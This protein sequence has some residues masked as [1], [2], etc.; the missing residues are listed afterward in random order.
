MLGLGT[1]P[2][3]QPI[4]P[5]VQR[6]R[7]A[8]R[9]FVLG[10]YASAVH[11][12]WSGP[13]G[14]QRI[15]AVAVASEPE[16]FWRGD[17]VEEIIGRI[18]LPPGAGRLEPAGER[19]NG[20]SGRALDELFLAPLGLTRNEAWLCDLVPH[21]CMNPG[22]KRALAERYRP[23]MK[24]LGLPEPE[25]PSL[26]AYLADEQRRAEIETELWESA[27]DIVITLG[28]QPLRW[29]TQYY[30]SRERLADCGLTDKEYGR[31]HSIRVGEREV[32]LLP[33]VHPRQ[34]GKLGSHSSRWAE[35]HERWGDEVAGRLLQ[36]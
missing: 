13:D 14:R 4:L 33:L 30:G 27:A 23:E 35:L 26:P 16:I 6:D 19:F 12:C 29:F 5:V 18:T 34:A 31:L 28:D 9:V 20:P 7:S 11:A 36:E 17:G 22:Q 25:W 2:F 1:F 15:S 24:R 32:G 3:G 8:E 10:V 21:S